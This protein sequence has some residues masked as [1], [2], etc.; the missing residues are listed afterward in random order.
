MS[1]HQRDKDVGLWLKRNPV[2]AGET[3][4]ELFLEIEKRGELPLNQSS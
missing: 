4:V 2:I 3:A 1:Q